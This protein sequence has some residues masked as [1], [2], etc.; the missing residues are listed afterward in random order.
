[1]ATKDV[2]WIQD[3]GHA[4]LSVPIEAVEGMTFTAYSFYDRNYAYLEEDCDAMAFVKQGG[5]S[6]ED[7]MN[8]RGDYVNE[9]DRDRRRFESNTPFKNPWKRG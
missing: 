9:F 2:R 6:V 4:W 3:P 1:M 5:C 8:A 7:L